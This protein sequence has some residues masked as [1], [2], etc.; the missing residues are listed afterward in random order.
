MVK[1]ICIVIYP[2]CHVFSQHMSFTYSFCVTDMVEQDHS[3]SCNDCRSDGRYSSNNVCWFL[4]VGTCVSHGIHS[5]GTYRYPL[6]FS[7]L[8]LNTH[9]HQSIMI[10]LY[11]YLSHTSNTHHHQ[12]III[13]LSIY[14]SL[15]LMPRT[16]IITK[17]S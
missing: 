14:L 13:Y 17:V 1:K 2:A 4:R 10:Y 7:T 11:M 5:M 16:P 8:T 15:S 6:L 9:H 3:V 12:I